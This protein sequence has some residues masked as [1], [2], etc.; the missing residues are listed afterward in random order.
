MNLITGQL[1]SSPI[2]PLFGKLRG[3]YESNVPGCAPTGT[4]ATP[5]SPCRSI[6]IGYYPESGCSPDSSNGRSSDKGANV[7]FCR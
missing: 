1:G 3:I 7:F 2:Q 5:A 6:S 4:N